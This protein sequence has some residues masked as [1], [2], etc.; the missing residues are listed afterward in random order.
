MNRPKILIADDHT[1]VAEACRKLLEPK[2]DVVDVV[3]DG[4]TLLRV[5]SQMRPDVVIA[6]ILMPELNGLDAGEQLKRN[7]P[8]IKLIFLSMH[9]RPEVAAEGFRRGASAYV[10]KHCTGEELISAVHQV[11][12]GSFYLSPQISKET[13]EF[14]GRTDASFYEDKHLT[15]RQRE[16]LQLLAEGK[17]MKQI[18]CLLNLTYCT[19]CFHKH[20][21][22]ETLDLR[23]SAELI[24]YAIRQLAV[25]DP[26]SSRPVHLRE[27]GFRSR[28]E[29]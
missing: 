11:L 17:S 28:P 18:A 14:L 22:M 6:D 5:A 7:N 9:L 26:S 15:Y 23:T 3:P 8:E 4:R 19:V 21:I 25:V 12:Q 29:Y 27:A 2:F 16:V 10:V 13:V 24:Q 20:R 1:L